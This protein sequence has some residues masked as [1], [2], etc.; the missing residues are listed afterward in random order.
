[1]AG[2]T[3]DFNT[4]HNKKFKFLSK[5]ECVKAGLTKLDLE[6][7]TIPEPKGLVSGKTD[8]FGK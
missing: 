1:M 8:K 3:E 5:E 7:N 4:A 2:K 6:N